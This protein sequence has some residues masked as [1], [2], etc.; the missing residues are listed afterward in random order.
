MKRQNKIKMKYC[1][2]FVTLL[3]VL[4]TAPVMAE[5]D[6]QP[7]I[8]ILQKNGSND[9]VITLT[10]PGQKGIKGLSLD[11]TIEGNSKVTF[12]NNVSWS[13]PQSDATTLTP[14]LSE[15]NKKLTLIATSKDLLKSGETLEIAMVSVSGA[16]KAGFSIKPSE[17]TMVENERYDKLLY[18][19][20][21]GEAKNLAIVEAEK[22]NVTSLSLDSYELA[23]TMGKDIFA[24]LNA[25]VEPANA[26]ITWNSD[27]PSVAEVDNNG[28]VTAKK[29]GKAN[30]TAKAGDITKKCAVTV[31]NFK[32]DNDSVSISGLLS[33]GE[34]IKA[35]AGN[36]TGNWKWARLDEENQEI[37]Q[38]NIIS[39]ANTSTYTLSDE[40]DVNRYIAVLFTGTGNYSGEATCVVGPVQKGTQAKPELTIESS[41][42]NQI[43]IKKVEGAQYSLDGEN[44]TENNQFSEL[45]AGSFTIYARMAETATHFASE[46]ATISVDVEKSNQPALV[47]EKIEDQEYH[48]DGNTFELKTT[49]GAGSGAVTF[50]LDKAYEEKAVIEGDKLKIKAAGSYLVYASKAADDFYNETKSAAYTVTVRQAESP[51]TQASIIKEE[52]TL[53]IH[54]SV[55]PEKVV[56]NQKEITEIMPVEGKEG[57]YN[58]KLPEMA[59]ENRAVVHVSDNYKDAVFIIKLDSD[60]PVKPVDPDKESPG[61]NG[62]GMSTDSAS[63]PGQGAPYGSGN[64]STGVITDP[65][66]AAFITSGILIVM[67]AGLMAF[68]RKKIL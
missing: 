25:A 54:S 12:N 47:I 4:F 29:A 18:T 7:T 42:K 8:K 13:I 38:D 68:K 24:H 26:S 21:G 61:N 5:N 37:T 52:M 36:A 55:K 64:P 66:A 17:L 33:Y 48:P 16:D 41:D 3:L 46:A 67:L 22:I 60:K 63:S 56:W 49:G 6:A 39:G 15:D 30:I 2:L 35:D 1:A 65:G 58:V 32:L 27:N 10:D 45:P 43:T 20:V 28:W 40:K 50:S 11:L 59:E 19:D 51:V 34:S 44:W 62:G 14:K 23:L 31:Q 53:Q 57:L 9:Y